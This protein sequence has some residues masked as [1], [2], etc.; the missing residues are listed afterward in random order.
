MTSLARPGIGDRI[1]AAETFITALLHAAVLP[2]GVDALRHR[3]GQSGIARVA[4]QE[5]STA[6]SMRLPCGEAAAR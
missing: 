3:R 6:N 5:M 2:I 4:P 1:A